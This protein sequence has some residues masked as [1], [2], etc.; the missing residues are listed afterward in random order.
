MPQ[1][2]IYY[3]LGR[4]SLMSRGALD[5]PKLERLLAASDEAEVGRVLSEI[6]WSTDADMESAAAEHIR[7]A[8][9]AV[10]ELST[11]E[12]TLDCFL[13]RYDV[14]NLKI[15]LKSRCLGL[16]SAPVS[17]CGVI[18]PDTLRHAVQE[19]NYRVL[20]EGLKKAADELE[21]QL[22]VKVDPF[23]I[24]SALDKAMYA[25]ILE[26]CPK[27]D[28]T[29]LAYFTA[30]IDLTNL[31]MALRA[32]AISRPMPFFRD[33]L[34]EGGSTPKNQWLKAYEAPERLPETVKKYGQ[35]VFAAALAAVMDKDKIPALEKAADDY[36]MHL[37]LPFKQVTDKNEKLIGYL[38]MRQREAAAVK[39]IIAGKKG[40]F[41]QAAI[42]ERL[43]ELYG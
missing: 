4:I 3:A 32:R 14:N 12:K 43:R 24:D 25:A 40:G 22:A 5:K 30:Q 33:I 36:L 17:D 21:K 41:S 34:I 39:L 9:Q 10:R 15:L 28:K 29:A 18:P 20:P 27:S 35:K 42:Q 38:L 8:C 19:R 1:L 37:Y 6:G 31:K 13:M 7:K 11:D 26:K 16:E 23:L 2:S